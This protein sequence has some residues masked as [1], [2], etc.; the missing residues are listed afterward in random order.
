M[1]IKFYD[2]ETNENIAITAELL[3]NTE[4]KYLTYL[5]W[6]MIELKDRKADE[7][8]LDEL[9]NL[10][11]TAGRLIHDQTGLTAIYRYQLSPDGIPFITQSEHLSH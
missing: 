4:L 9:N 11:A 8:S 6:L 3:N 1:P 10:I 7:E 2:R 5:F